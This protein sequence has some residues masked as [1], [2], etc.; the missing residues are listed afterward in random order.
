MSHAIDRAAIVEALFL[1]R[2]EPNY[3]LTSPL[4]W[5]H[6]PNVPRFEFDPDRANALMD[7]AGWTLGDDGVRTKDGER[8]EFTLN[9][10]QRFQEWALAIQPMLAAIGIAFQINVLE[11]GTWIAQLEVGKYEGAVGG[12][13]NFII[14]PR[15]DLQA[16]F[17]SPR[18]V[19][20]TGYDN[21]E[22]DELFVQARLAMSREDEKELY[23]QIQEIVEG[24][25]VY[26]YLWR[27][28][29]LLVVRSDLSVPE[30]STQG[31]LYARLPE[32]EVQAQA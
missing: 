7:E 21:E 1:G 14:D 3:S 24:D 32:W 10:T 28:Q 29:D 16:Q 2:A 18:P 27:P 4:S 26:V 13:I 25:A 15:A 19:D 6:N 11:F 22:V 9:L 20:A 17:E 8:F 5:I 12:W 23:D 30:V 31:E